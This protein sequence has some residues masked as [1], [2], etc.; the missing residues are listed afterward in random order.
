MEGE[1]TNP[2]LS[3]ELIASPDAPGSLGGGGLGT[4]W[5]EPPIFNAELTFH[6]SVS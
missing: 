5:P 6:K 2:L 1:E 3:T 4:D